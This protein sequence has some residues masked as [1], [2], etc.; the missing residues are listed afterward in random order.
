LLDNPRLVHQF[1]SLERRQTRFGKDR[2]DH[3]QYGGADDLCNSAA[4]AAVLVATDRR[5]GLV[6]SSDLLTEGAPLP[7]PEFAMGVF[8][9][10][11]VSKAGIAAVV[12]VAPAFIEGGLHI[13]D[14]DCAPLSGDTF[15]GIVARV[16]ELG[17]GCRVPRDT[18][19]ALYVAPEL[20]RTLMVAGYTA[21]EIPEHLLDVEALLVPA[22]THIAAG[23][24]KLC[25]PAHEKAKTSPFGGALDFRGGDTGDDPLR[26]AALWAIALGLDPQ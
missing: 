2:V 15:S 22:A 7:L 24:A 26:R 25:K 12:Y 18:S 5:P 10:V 21:D 23:N 4:G 14:Y 11:A 19:I 8:A 20:V 16:T 13:L 1:V 9:T 17:R 3:P 6:R